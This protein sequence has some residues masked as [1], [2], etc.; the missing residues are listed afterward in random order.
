MERLVQLMKIALANVVAFKMKAQFYHWNVTGP[1]FYQY[2]EFFGEI[3]EEV[4]GSIDTIAELIRTLNAFAPGSLARFKE[5][6]SIN[7]DDTLASAYIMADNL[8]QE[9]N[10]VIASL[11]VAYSAAEEEGELGV[12]NYLQDRIQ[13]HQKHAWFLRSVK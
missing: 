3:Y 2:H 7:E 5:L 12:S 4:D 11:M 6:T 9:N 13:A 10:K 1:D 8:L